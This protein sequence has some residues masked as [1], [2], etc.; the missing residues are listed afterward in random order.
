MSIIHPTAIVEDGARLGAD[1]TVGA[2]SIVGRDV[3][4]EDGVTLDAHVLI[5]GR[6]VIG[7]AIGSIRREVLDGRADATAGRVG[8]GRLAVDLV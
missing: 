8:C 2:F 1:V 7:A 5:R 4:L 6:T 3:T